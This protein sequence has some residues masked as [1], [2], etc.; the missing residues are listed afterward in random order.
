MFSEQRNAL[1]QHLVAMAKTI[2]NHTKTPSAVAISV[3][4]RSL[5]EAALPVFLRTRDDIG[6]NVFHLSF[7]Q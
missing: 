7:S 1:F 5:H 4:G 6:M 2:G 3:G